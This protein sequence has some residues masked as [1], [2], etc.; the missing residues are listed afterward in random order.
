MTCPD[1]FPIATNWLIAKAD[2][3]RGNRKVLAA[4]HWNLQAPGMDDVICSN[5]HK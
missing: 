5:T 1:L 4:I 2:Q 3:Q